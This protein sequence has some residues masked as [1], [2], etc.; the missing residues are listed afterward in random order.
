MRVQ[1][2]QAELH[3]QFSL[4][5]RNI[6]EDTTFNCVAQN[7]LGVANWTIHVNLIDGLPSLQR[8]SSFF[9]RSKAELEGR[10]CHLKTGERRSRSSLHR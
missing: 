10:L 2:K 9:F 1:V 5:V 7:P 8:P 4:E 6:T 3:A